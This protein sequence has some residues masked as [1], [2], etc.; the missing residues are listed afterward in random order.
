MEQQPG[1]APKI[2][3]VH[4]RKSEE[5]G[6]Y[7]KSAYGWGVLRVVALLSGSLTEF[8]LCT[9]KADY[10]SGSKMKFA[11]PHRSKDAKCTNS[12]LQ[13]ARKFRAFSGYHTLADDD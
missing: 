3:R 8:C 11:F 7:R 13:R 10:R 1:T 9:A 2:R 12:P 5:R 4:S 6:K